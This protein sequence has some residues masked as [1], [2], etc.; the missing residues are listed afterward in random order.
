MMEWTLN[1]QTRAVK[2][3]LSLTAEVHTLVL[4]PSWHCVRHLWWGL[5]SADNAIILFNLLPALCS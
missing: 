5:P 2:K 1:F 3:H 4:L